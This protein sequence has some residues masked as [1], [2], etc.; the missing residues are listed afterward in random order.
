[1][2]N[3]YHKGLDS[4]EDNPDCLVLIQK[5]RLFKWKENSVTLNTNFKVQKNDHIRWEVKSKGNQVAAELT[6]QSIF[7]EDGLQ[8]DNQT[9]S[10]TIRNVKGSELYS[11]QISRGNIVRKYNVIVYAPLPEP[12]IKR[13]HSHCSTSAPGCSIVPKCLLVCSVSNVSSVNL[14]WYKGDSSLSNTSLETECLDDSHTCVVSYTFTSRSKYPSSDMCLK[15][16]DL[17]SHKLLILLLTS[18]FVLL[19]IT[20]VVGSLLHLKYKQANKRES[21]NKD[22]DKCLYQSVVAIVE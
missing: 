6:N 13:D 19:A 17:H 21:Q 10:L 4:S 22:Q 16:S 12:D 5:Y 8:L 18:A 7:C 11:L 1:M 20:I 2:L 15:C 14:T 3:L 9:G